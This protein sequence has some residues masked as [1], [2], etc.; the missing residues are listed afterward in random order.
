[1]RDARDI[2]TIIKTLRD[3]GRAVE[4]RDLDGAR[5]VRDR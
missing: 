2:E 1:V 5:N 3:A 4:T